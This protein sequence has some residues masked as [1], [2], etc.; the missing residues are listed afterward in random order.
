MDFDVIIIG[1]GLG[2]LTAGATLSRFGKKVLLIEQHYIPGGCATSFKRKGYLMEVGL[3]EMDGLHEYDT[4]RRIFDLL[5]IWDNIELKQVPELYRIKGNGF[6]LVVPHGKAEYINQLGEAYPD[7]KQA[8]SKLLNLM[9]GVLKEVPKLPSGWKSKL[10]FPLYPILFPNIVKTSELTLGDWLDRNIKSEE[11]KLIIQGN[12]AYYSDDPYKMSLL[13]FSVAQSSYIGGGGNFIKGGSQN[14]SNYLAKEIE[15]AGGQVILGKKVTNILVE[16]NKVCGVKFID[17]F[18]S[19]F[20]SKKVYAPYIIGNAAIPLIKKMLP[21]AQAK[22]LGKRIDGLEEACSLISIYIG[23]NKNLKEWGVKNYSTFLFGDEI[24][25]LKDVA[26]VNKSKDWKNK[27]FVFVDYSQIDS[28]LCERNKSVGVIC[29]IDYLEDWKDLSSKQYKEKKEIVAKTLFNRLEEN[30]PGITEFIDHYEVGTAKTV[31]SYTLNPKGT[32]YGYAQTLEQSGNNRLPARSPIENLYFASAWS[33]PGGGFTGAIIGGFLTGVEVSK[34]LKSSIGSR[35]YNDERVVSL[36]ERNEIAQDT[37][38]LVIDKPK[39]FDYLPGQYAILSINNAK[40]TE[41]DLPH[42]P[43]SMVSHPDE[44]K[45]R[46]AMRSSGSSFKKS[47]LAMKVGDKFTIYGPI[48]NF[49]IKNTNRPIVFLIGGIGITPVIPLLKEL[50]LNK[51]DNEIHLFYTNRDK[52][53]AAY[54]HYL[55]KLNFDNYIY[56]PVL[57]SIDGRLNK[58]KLAILNDMNK[59]DYYIVGTSGFLKSMVELLKINKVASNHIFYDDF[60]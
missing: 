59:Y 36:Y 7:D 29:A 20:G 57:T 22:K 60:G 3:H 35:I 1:S 27:P 6:D 28:G 19:T 9:E 15:N 26:R 41:L 52:E 44:P 11:L 46:F 23:F 4:K 12:L 43:L 5:E 2:G 51:F 32:P 42:R 39:N 34:R 45:L 31:Q 56:H 25:S 55:K 49:N 21:K 47:C 37:F 10:I 18:N 16:N 50:K 8:L 17:S 40:F 30:F 53:K 38:E 33:N 24:N 54:Y 14:L 48:G 58:D 13:Y